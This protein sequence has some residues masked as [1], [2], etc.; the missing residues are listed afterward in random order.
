M[1]ETQPERD[2][3]CRAVVR[4]ADGFSETDAGAGG[5]PGVSDAARHARTLRRDAG[6]SVRSARTRSGSRLGAFLP[7]LPSSAWPRPACV[8]SICS[9]NTRPSSAT[10][11]IWI[12]RVRWAPDPAAAGR[13][14]QSRRARVPGTAPA[15]RLESSRAT[16]RHA[17]PALRIRGARMGGRGPRATGRIRLHGLNVRPSAP[18]GNGSSRLVRF[19]QRPCAE[20][21]RR[22]PPTPGRPPGIALH[23]RVALSHSGRRRS[24]VA[25]RVAVRRTASAR[26]GHARLGTR[27]ARQD[28]GGRGRSWSGGQGA[29][30]TGIARSARSGRQG[31][32]AR[33]PTSEPQQWC[34]SAATVSGSRYPCCSTHWW[35]TA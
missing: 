20:R 19:K 29:V 25:G 1:V 30:R 17:R 5:C 12:S 3:G 18:P 10:C 4:A 22:A 23:E 28:V 9:A 35:P 34:R 14:R 6:R 16:G 11:G 24:L 32:A 15:G 13:R 31:R 8:W 26:R 27:R 33:R 2:P 7:F 21:D